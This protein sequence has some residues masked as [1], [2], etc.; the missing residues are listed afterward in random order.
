MLKFGSRPS[1]QRPALP[2]SAGWLFA[3]PPVLGLIAKLHHSKL[4]FGD[5]QAVACAGQKMLAGAP[6]YA[7]NLSCSGMHASSFVYLPAVARLAAFL[8]SLCGEH[9]FFVIYLLVYL[10]AA[11]A[12]TVMPLR[13]SPLPGTRG[14]L[15][16]LSFLSGSAFMWGNIAVILHGAVLLAALSLESLPWLFVAAVVIAAW[17][18]PVFLTYL[19]VILLAQLTWRRR[20]IMIAVAIVCG[21]APMLIFSLSGGELARQW[22]TL[23]S[24]FVYDQTPGAGWFGWFQMAGL[25]PSS[26]TAKAG[27]L[28]YAALLSAGGLALA[29]ALK[30]TRHERLWFGFSLAVLLI[31]RL[32]SQ[33]M[34]LLGP[35]LIIIAGRAASAG[36][37][38]RGPAIILGL[39]VLCLIGGLTTVAGITT[40]L[41]VLGFA[42]Y[43]LWASARLALRTFKPVSD[44]LAA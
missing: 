3:L 15:P 16:F 44:G 27:Y 32:M 21:L 1:P 2:V 26:M 29:E 24:H 7:R 20:L 19:A 23:L 5:Y 8:Q 35:G 43:L 38:P 33:D 4:W 17:V 41:A 22:Y 36:L 37:T 34:F 40:P 11:A 30:L 39:C 13:L 31:P 25:S 28:I 42:L 18:K 9:G 14:Q 6:I 12:L 10:M